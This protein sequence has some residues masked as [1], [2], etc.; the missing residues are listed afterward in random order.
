MT[1]NPGYVPL[2]T[3]LIAFV[4]VMILFDSPVTNER[5]RQLVDSLSTVFDLADRDKTFD[6]EGAG[7]D[8]YLSWAAVQN[9]ALRVAFYAWVAEEEAAGYSG[10]L[11]DPKFFYTYFIENVETRVGPQIQRFGIQQAVPWFGTLGARKDVSSESAKA[12]YQ[13]FES[14]K[15]RL[16][17]EVKSAFYEHYYLGRD[18]AITR[19]NLELLT[20]WESVARARYRVALSGP[21]IPR[22]WA[23]SVRTLRQ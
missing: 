19:D 16:F 13:R 7:L 8:D 17:Y 15:L 18:I 2:K 9:Q 22:R 3:I 14:R 1:A 4:T 5:S 21:S 11:P 10:S 23:G 6:P 20:F 12:A